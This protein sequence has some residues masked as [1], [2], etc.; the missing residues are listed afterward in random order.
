MYLLNL[1]GLSSNLCNAD[2]I[3]HLKHSLSFLFFTFITAFLFLLL[4]LVNQCMKRL[5]IEITDLGIN[6]NDKF[7]SISNLS[8]SLSMDLICDCLFEQSEIQSNH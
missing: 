2:K 7:Y 8:H 3:A 6:L 4:F 5:L 1:C